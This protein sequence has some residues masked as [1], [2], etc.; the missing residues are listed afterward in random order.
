MVVG[1]LEDAVEQQ[2]AAAA[3]E[4]EHELVEVVRWVG[5]VDGALMGAS[6]DAQD[7]KIHNGV[8]RAFS[9]LKNWR[10]LASR[11]D[12]HALVNR[13]GVVLASIPL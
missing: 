4:A 11:N 13:G 9:R 6:S 1:D 7:Y 12:K 5:V 10:T 2:A 8:E 3:V